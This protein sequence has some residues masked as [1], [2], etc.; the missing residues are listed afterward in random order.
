[1]LSNSNNEDPD[2]PIGL[3]LG[4][5]LNPQRDCTSKKQKQFGLEHRDKARC[6]KLKDILGVR[7]VTLNKDNDKRLF[8]HIQSNFNMSKYT[9]TDIDASFPD[10]SFKNVLYVYLDH[11]HSPVCKYY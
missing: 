1:M 9:Q 8:H 7:V 4:M 5:Y 11:F 10:G 2:V 6:I 3:C